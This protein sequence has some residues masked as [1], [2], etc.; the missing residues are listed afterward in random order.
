MPEPAR[1]LAFDLPVEPQLGID[2]FLVGAAN[3]QA[4][5]RITGWPDWPGRLMHLAGPEGSG[6]SHL[7]AIWASRAGA[8]IRPAAR[9]H[10][11]DVP[12][13]AAAG[14]LVVEDLDRGELDEAALFH[15]LNLLR[16]GAGFLLVTSAAPIDRCGLLL[17]D[18]RSRLR[19]APT[20]SLGEPDD[21]LLRAVLVKLFLD[22]QLLVDAS[23]L[24][25][26]AARIE[27]SFG[28]AARIVAELDREA[29]S[30]G[31]RVTRSVAA[32]VLPREGWAPDEA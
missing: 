27:R 9:I 19:L 10:E 22:R 7:A 18:L 30:R 25:F 24:G 16:E 8:T 12:A 1:Q 6:K 28:A 15:L 20:L 26:L 13:L 21:A 31:R 2:D 17:P 14:A 23:V 5:R 4:F 32:S 11:A 29:L 3:E